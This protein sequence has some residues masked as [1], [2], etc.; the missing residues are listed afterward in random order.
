M[1]FGLTSQKF[2]FLFQLYVI[3]SSLGQSD[4][5]QGRLTLPSKSRRK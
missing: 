4:E 3:F 1:G 5:K 2:P